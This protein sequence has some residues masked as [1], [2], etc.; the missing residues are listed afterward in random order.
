MGTIIAPILQMYTLK[1]RVQG[2]D[3]L[4]GSEVV[5]GEPEETESQNF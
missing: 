3:F 1:S 4:L 5:R 2:K